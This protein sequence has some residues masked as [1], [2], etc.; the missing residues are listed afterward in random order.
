MPKETQGGERAKTMSAALDQQPDPICE[1]CG[2]S[3]TT[4]TLEETGIVLCLKCLEP[5]EAATTWHGDESE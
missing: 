3:G 5:A 4:G 1:Q 2:K